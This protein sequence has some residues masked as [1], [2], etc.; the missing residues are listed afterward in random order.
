MDN[1]TPNCN[2]HFINLKKIKFTHA[3]PTPKIKVRHEYIQSQYKDV[4]RDT[5]SCSTKWWMEIFELFCKFHL[6]LCRAYQH[7]LFEVQIEPQHGGERL[8]PFTDS[9][10][11]MRYIYIYIMNP[12]RWVGISNV[13]GTSTTSKVSQWWLSRPWLRINWLKETSQESPSS[14]ILQNTLLRNNS[15][16]SPNADNESGPCPSSCKTDT[17]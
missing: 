9:R 7:S 4:Y 8:L 5:F 3:S 12:K 13:S 2:L 11:S 17:L 15:A 1:F 6:M 16:P 10:S 14:D